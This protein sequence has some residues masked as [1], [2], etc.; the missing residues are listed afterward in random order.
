MHDCHRCAAPSFVL[1]PVRPAQQQNRNGFNC[2][3]PGKFSRLAHEGATAGISVGT[4]N[5]TMTAPNQLHHAVAA[6]ATAAAAPIQRITKTFG[7]VS[8][9][10]GYWGPVTASIDWC[11]SNYRIT[12][13]IAEFFNSTSNLFTVVAGISLA[14][15]ARRLQ[16]ERRYALIGFFLALVG[17][18]SF[19]FHGTL[20]FEAQLLDE[21]PM[22]YMMLQFLY[23]ILEN[24]PRRKYPWLP[25]AL[26]A[27]AAVY[28]WAHVYFDFV[29][30]FHVVFGALT[31]P[32]LIFAIP[33]GWRDR[34]L[35]WVFGLSYA[36]LWIS[37]AFWKLDQSFCPT[38]EH[39][40][41]HAVWHAGTAISAVLW[42]K[43]AMAVRLRDA[44]GRR[45]AWHWYGLF[46]LIP[47][48]SAARPRRRASSTTR[49]PSP[50]DSGTADSPVVVSG[51]AAAR[52]GHVRTNSGDVVGIRLAGRA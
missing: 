21:L 37:F 24:E 32:G 40:Y 44:L 8:D 49:A 18:G 13:Y 3:A 12:H 23:V 36:C 16:L 11:E 2:R 51:V 34:E 46:R 28:S 47:T 25:T 19:M 4:S 30:V 29:V 10:V 14:M 45:I 52:R 17:V 41:L 38:L 39:L 33:H 15:T 26:V 7:P 27:V 50:T 43:G 31:A 5:T 35:Q 22:I 20:L 48:L 1:S 42:A 6:A 9:T